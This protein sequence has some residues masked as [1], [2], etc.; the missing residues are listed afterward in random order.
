MMDTPVGISTSN[1]GP[2]NWWITTD[3][4]TTLAEPITQILTLMK[5]AEGEF[6][7]TGNNAQKI[8]MEYFEQSPELWLRL[9]AVKAE[10]EN[11]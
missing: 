1:T 8:L 3:N 11:D 10:R 7:L 6:I 2:G 5:T 9:M 4:S